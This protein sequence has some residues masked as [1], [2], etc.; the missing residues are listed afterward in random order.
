MRV[1]KD[2]LLVVPSFEM[3]LVDVLSPLLIFS[4]CDLDVSFGLF[5]SIGSF[6]IWYTFSPIS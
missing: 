5:E 3:E 1:R 4:Y 2:R 6:L